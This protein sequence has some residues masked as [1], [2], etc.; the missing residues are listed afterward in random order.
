MPVSYSVNPDAGGDA[1]ANFII[2]A[3]FVQVNKAYDRTGDGAVIGVRYSITLT[4]TLV[5]H[6]GSPDYS[7]L[8]SLNTTD[9]RNEANVP[10]ETEMYK[11]I[12]N[13]Q[14][15]MRKLFAHHNE[16]GELHIIPLDGG[17]LGLKCNPRIVS[18]DFNQASGQP[19]LMTYTIQ[20]ETDELR[21]PPEAAGTTA[22][23]ASCSGGGHA[24]KVL[25]EGAGETWTP[26][27]AL[28]GKTIK[29][30]DIDPEGRHALTL[31]GVKSKFFNFAVSSA[32]ENWGIDEQ[33][34]K[35][36]LI[37]DVDKNQ[38]S[39]S[40]KTGDPDFR[41]YRHKNAR[42]A[43]TLSG[44]KEI[45][46]DAYKTA[47]DAVTAEEEKDDGDMSIVA[48]EAKI[49]KNYKQVGGYRI[50]KVVKTYLLTHSVSATGKRVFDNAGFNKEA[51]TGSKTGLEETGSLLDDMGTN[52]VIPAAF[53][54][55]NHGKS[56]GCDTVANM[57]DD[58]FAADHSGNLKEKD[59]VPDGEAWQQARGYVLNYISGTDPIHRGGAYQKALDSN[60]STRQGQEGGE[61]ETKERWKGETGFIDL[62]GIN[63]PRISGTT[64]TRDGKHRY[65][66]C[67]YKRVQTIDKTSGTFAVTETWVLADSELI[68]D[69]KND[70]GSTID[71]GLVAETMEFSSEESA[72]DG[73]TTV[74]MNGTI[75][76]LL[77]ATDEHF[78]DK[79]AE[80]DAMWNQEKYGKKPSSGDFVGSTA[81]R[82]GVVDDSGHTE[83]TV[84]CTTKYEEALRRFYWLEPK[85]HEIAQTSTGKWINPVKKS[86][87][88]SR[89]PVAGTINYSVS[90]GTGNDNCFPCALSESVVVNDTHPSHV[91]A[92]TSVLGRRMGPVLQDI[93]TQTSWKRNLSVDLSVSG[94][95]HGCDWKEAMKA[96]PSMKIS[97]CQHPFYTNKAE[98]LTARHSW[99]NK[100][101]QPCNQGTVLREVI[102]AISPRK[103]VGITNYFVSSGPNES[104]DAIN[105]KYTFAI[106]W[107]YELEEGPVEGAP[108]DAL[109]K[110]IGKSYLGTQMFQYPRTFERIDNAE[111]T[112]NEQITHEVT[113]PEHMPAW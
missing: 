52:Q 5:A 26:A 90:F 96:K 94:V 8:F 100:K 39:T 20:L 57:A 107:T 88:V 23:A 47:Q 89:N 72:D 81:S 58:A 59:S 92:E 25:C 15:A 67:D 50:A 86:F 19:N 109:K 36:L 43:A 16:G 75:T 99:I 62:F 44:Y 102:D 110:A 34:H 111:N 45:T 13:K 4:G 78:P 112:I 76:G 69:I 6:R 73:T 79:E 2:P 103:K 84:K 10:S 85:L 68:K 1:V 21:G 22:S 18:M 27:G 41:R 17:K 53:K 97:G 14:M 49:L 104:W 77:E 65:T 106:E 32:S 38:G 83:K 33:D 71:I 101:Q 3:P 93:N 70:G 37:E 7:G 24:T 60:E 31:D 11:S 108:E 105:G 80:V 66:G 64:T 51:T 54:E 55:P 42:D 95:I 63:L 113:E 82:A 46:V 40:N 98:C 35:Q 87:S 28:L 74:S 61:S 30:L 29:G 91:F 9:P 56:E 12:Q 48:D